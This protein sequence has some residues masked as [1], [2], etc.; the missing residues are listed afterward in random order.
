MFSS[1]FTFDPSFDF[2]FFTFFYCMF[3]L[4][5]FS[6][7]AI[8]RR[9]FPTSGNLY[10]ARCNHRLLGNTLLAQGTL[11]MCLYVLF[12]KCLVILF[13]CTNIYALLLIMYC[14]SAIAHL[15]DVFNFS[16]L[17]CLHLSDISHFRQSPLSTLRPGNTQQYWSSR[18]SYIYIEYENKYLLTTAYCL[19]W[20]YMLFGIFTNN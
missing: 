19:L 20:F 15:L 3:A 2:M 1:N 7:S 9:T 14:F 17:Q 6:T 4:Y 16:F 12:Y 18:S 8:A 5:C 13:I 10:S 11:I